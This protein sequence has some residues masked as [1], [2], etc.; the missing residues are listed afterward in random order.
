MFNSFCK[1][2]IIIIGMHFFRASASHVPPRN[3]MSFQ[4]TTIHIP[5]KVMVVTSQT[6]EEK[7]S[8]VQNGKKIK[9]GEPFWIL[10]HVLAEKI[11][12]SEFPRLR[13][14]LLNLVLTICSNL[15]CPECTNHAIQYLNGINFNTIRTKNDF[16]DMMY[17]FHNSVNVRKEYPIFPR[18]GL[19]K[20]SRGNVIP[21]IEN[22][23][24]HFLVNHKNFHLLADDIQRRRI[25]QG[26]KKWFIENIGA[27]Y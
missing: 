11:K 9:W 23:M 21:I 15:P 2:C 18:E 26:V 7:V 10:F 19:E 17:N 24:L 14:G 4:R 22:F 1:I 6:Y 13:E 27:F 3:M 25:S 16:K 20:Y 8:S 12:E 5:S